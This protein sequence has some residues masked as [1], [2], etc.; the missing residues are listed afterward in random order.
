MGEI[1]EKLKEARE[2]IGIPIEEASAD[3]KISIEQLKNLE[4]GNVE[5][6]KDIVNVKYLIRDYAKYLGLDKDDLVDDFNEYLFD[7]TSKIS[8]DDI[9]EAKEHKNDNRIKSP[10]TTIN[11]KKSVNIPLIIVIILLL[12]SISFIVYYNITNNKKDNIIVYVEG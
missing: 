4:H 9:K 10:Y 5:T 1:G 8:L 3:L 7:Y 2:A 11:E 12:L 6:F